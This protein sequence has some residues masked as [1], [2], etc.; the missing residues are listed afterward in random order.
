MDVIESE[1]AQALLAH[2]KDLREPHEPVRLGLL[3]QAL[4][5]RRHGD[6]HGL[7][8]APHGVA[9]PRGQAGLLHDRGHRLAQH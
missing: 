7:G 1:L 9:L 8:A 2:F 4:K 6:P 3:P 5:V